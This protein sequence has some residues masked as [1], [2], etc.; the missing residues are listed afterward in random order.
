M[1]LDLSN[2][3]DRIANIWSSC[4]VFFRD[5][6]KKMPL[7]IWNV[8]HVFK[9]VLAKRNIPKLT[10]RVR[11]F[12]RRMPFKIISGF[13]LDIIFLLLKVSIL[14]LLKFFWCLISKHFSH[15]GVYTIKICYQN[16]KTRFKLPLFHHLII[17]SQNLTAYKAPDLLKA[18]RA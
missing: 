9:I 17:Q 18:R 4:Y 3:K 7:K 1:P 12:N 11:Q 14:F 15:L 6:N 13:L 5:L 2:I 8:E 10:A 16:L